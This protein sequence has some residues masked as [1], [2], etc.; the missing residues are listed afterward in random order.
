LKTTSKIIKNKLIAAIV[1]V[2]RNSGFALAK[3]AIFI[4]LNLYATRIKF[5]QT[6]LYL[7]NT[8][9]RA[10]VNVAENVICLK[11]ITFPKGGCTTARWK[12]KSIKN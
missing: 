5:D 2:T 6:Y 9:L 10:K 12:N 3:F 4:H 11:H 7:R 8:S 1:S